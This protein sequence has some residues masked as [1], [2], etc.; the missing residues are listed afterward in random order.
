[1]IIPQLSR[2]NPEKI[3][4]NVKNVDGGGSITTGMGVCLAQ[5]AA[6]ADGFSAIKQQGS[7]FQNTFCGVALQDIPINGYGLVTAWGFAASVLISQSVGSF[8]ITSG[9][10]LISAGATQAGAFTSV[11]TAQALST[12]LYKWVIAAGSLV[13]T[14]SNPRPY[15]SGIVRA[16]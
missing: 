15:I 12:Q 14:I 9:D 10:N 6:S 5:A 2:D 1:M 3:L 13:D 7:S 4:I 11:V 8:T 16:I